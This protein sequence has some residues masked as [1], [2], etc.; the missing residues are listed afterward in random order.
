M[1]FPLY[2][3]EDPH[4]FGRE[5]LLK[6]IT[7][8]LLHN[9]GDRRPGC[10]ALTGIPGVGKTCLAK[11]V[12]C[13]MKGNY[14]RLLWFSAETRSKLLQDFLEVSRIL[15]LSPKSALDDVEVV[16]EMVLDHITNSSSLPLP[17]AESGPY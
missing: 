9:L 13:K 8:H 6:E 1:T 4:F 15:N 10:V 17:D 7:G 5:E 2:I 16:R 12:Q 14:D 11:R 3:S